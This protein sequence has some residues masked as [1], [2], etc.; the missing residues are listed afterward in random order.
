V[1]P[2]FHLG[3]FWIAY[4]DKYRRPEVS[5]KYGL[6]LDSWWVDPTAEQ[7]IEAKKGEANKG[8]ANKQ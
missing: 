4:W 7:A 1:I 5:P 6:G 2:Q 3:K 8:E